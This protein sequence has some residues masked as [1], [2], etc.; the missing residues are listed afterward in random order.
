MSNTST[1]FVMCFVLFCFPF[2]Y[3]LK[4]GYINLNISRLAVLRA[5]GQISF[6]AIVTRGDRTHIYQI[7]EDQKTM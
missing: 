3:V 7:S 1:L 6:L 4:L 2:S 5:A